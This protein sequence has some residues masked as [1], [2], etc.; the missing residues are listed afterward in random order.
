MRE[1]I[2]NDFSK[3]YDSSEGASSIDPRYF[4]NVPI[5][6]APMSRDELTRLIRMY[7]EMN[8]QPQIFAN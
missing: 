6:G 2:V 8:R 1:S 5:T 7:Q 3:I 4:E